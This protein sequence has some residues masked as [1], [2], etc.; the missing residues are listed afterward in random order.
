[1]SPLLGF[2]ADEDNDIEFVLTLYQF[3]HITD[4]QEMLDVV[5]QRNVVSWTI[6][7]VGYVH[8]KHL[9]EAV[10]VFR[11]IHTCRRS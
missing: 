10:E 1:V 11:W 4:A 5:P 8:M 9:E 6:V 3:E 2:Y 7:A